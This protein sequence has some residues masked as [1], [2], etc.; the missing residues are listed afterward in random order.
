VDTAGNSNEGNI[1]IYTCEDKDDQ[2]FYFKE[3]GLIQS[4]GRLQVSLSKECIDVTGTDGR[5]D[6]TTAD[7]TPSY[8]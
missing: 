2:R 6:V 1:G 4:I 7:C 5:G 8:D 3:R